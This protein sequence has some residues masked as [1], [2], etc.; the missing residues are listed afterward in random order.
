MRARLFAAMLL[1]FS[2][3]LLGAITGTVINSDGKPVAGAK[4]SAF[5]LESSQARRERLRSTEPARKPLASTQTDVK[6]NFSIDAAKNAVVDVQV[7]AAGSLPDVTRVAADDGEAGVIQLSSAAMKQGAITAGGKPLAN[8]TVIVAT[9]TTD[10]VITTDAAG[11]YSLP[12]PAHSPSRV[13]VKHPDY[14]LASQT[15]ST[16]TP[17]HLDIAMDAGVALSGRVVAED[18][19]TP[20][21]NATIEV[22]D[23]PTTKTA[24]DG[25][26]TIAHA[27]K[28]WRHIVARIENRFAVRESGSDK[29]IVLRLAKAATVSGNV[30][31]SKTQLPLAGAEVSA[32]IARMSMSLR[33]A[34]SSSAITDAKGNFT[35]TDL[36]GGEYELSATR[37][38]YSMMNVRLSVTPGQSAQKT[39][40]GA[41]LGRIAGT[42]VDDDR[43]G[44]AGARL[45]PRATGDPRMMPMGPRMRLGAERTGRA[46]TA[47]DGHFLVRVEPD[48]DVQLEATRKGQPPARS[49]TMRVAA[50][51]RKSGVVITM[52]RGV[53]V[54]GR[55]MDRNNKPIAGVVVAATEPRNAG[56]GGGVRRM[57]ANAIRGG[58][59]DDLVRTAADGTF[60]LRVKEGTYDLG[61]KA[62]GFA[63]KT[64]RAVPVDAQAKPVEV[65]LEPGVEIRGRI[66]RGGAPVEGVNIIPIMADSM[67]PAETGP[68]GTFRLTDLTPGE[69]MLAYSKPDQLIQGMRAVTAPA[70]D[71]NIELPAGGRITGHV[72]DKA[73][74]QPV[75]TFEAGVSPSRSGG[76]MVMMMPP[77]MRSFTSDD[78]TFVLENVPVGASTV[79][80]TAPGYVEARVPNVIVENDKAGDAIEVT[81]ETGVHVTGKVTGPDG[82]A[83][84]GAVVRLEAGGGNRMRGIPGMS[85]YTVTDPNGEYV[86]EN[87]ENG[88][89]SFSF[90]RSG[91]I[92]ASK[93]VTLSGSSARVDAQ[94]TSGTRVTGVVVTEGGAPVADAMVRA[95]SAAEA[96]FGQGSRTDSNGSFSF[97]SLAP[98]HYSFEANK[99]GYADAIAH[100]VDI[101]TSGLV[102]LIMKN[103]GVISGHLSGLSATELQNA[104][105]RVDSPNGNA[106]APVDA[107][108]AYRVEGAPLGT[109]RVSAMTGQVMSSMRTAPP[110][111]VLVEAGSAVSVDFEFAG[112]ISVSG[113]VTRNGVPLAGVMISF[114]GGSLRS[115]SGNTDASGRYTV[116]GLDNGKYSI[117]IFD[118]ERGPYSTNYTVSGSATFDIDIRGVVVRGRVVD[119]SSGAALTDTQ[120][121]LRRKDGTS[122]PTSVTVTDAAGGFSFDSVPAGTYQ[123][124][125]EKTG[126]GATS[127][128]LV[129]G[130]TA[131]DALDIKLTPAAGIVLRVVDARDQRPLGAWYHAVGPKGE[132]YDDYIRFNSST[133]SLRIPLAPGTYRVT[134]GASDYAIQ[135]F[136]ID[137]PGQ[138]MVGLTP[139]G[140]IMVSTTAPNARGR[141]VDAAGQPYSRSG[142]RGMPQTFRIETDPL[143]SQ[144]DN[145]A[146]GEYTIEL[147]DEK[148]RVLRTTR[149]RV[150]DGQ[151][152]TVKL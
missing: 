3:P 47:P 54:T 42:V 65:T 81:M 21:E 40:Y 117:G 32:M 129:V 57:I 125:A 50:G 7:D 144:L 15:Q 101:T 25:T 84:G 120:V 147:L 9:L 26:F 143:Q 97:E 87:V 134:V 43:R 142:L 108:G 16:F 116:T 48:S 146:P 91:L 102:R 118:P 80:V 88:E 44:V 20:A 76:G 151:T 12:D 63:A 82:A 77:M 51:E 74:H 130:D 64:V 131:G 94:L 136:T 135:S 29:P 59:E 99:S 45:E 107:S 68:D 34:E 13:I 10:T 92:S 72:V 23:L 109:V 69:M 127:N 31:D 75:K 8:A 100:D 132:V 148:N 73:T 95:S 58:G 152:V 60:A 56:P 27:P 28:K 98:G 106:S 139:G 71:I 30:R 93:T 126:Y 35:I 70:S 17:G 122:F 137:S 4:V 111:T 67:T 124:S 41:Q 79:S 11:R 5:A 78:G 86:L 128:D 36:S 19:Q 61:F 55:V 110:K 1:L 53:A 37:P 150:L 62:S 39:L 2:F 114:R 119:A 46:V 18:G 104:T 145:I 38:G 6:G 123:A 105:V 103:G 14:A 66:T 140:T 141:L 83:V 113:R 89:K 138:R 121:S 96:G 22:D 85:P 149:V 90:S 24:A 115:G 49:T 112:D 133:E 52:P 33:E